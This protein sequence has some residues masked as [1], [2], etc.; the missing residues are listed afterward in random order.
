MISSSDI[1]KASILIVDD[2]EANVSLLEQ[3]LRGAGYV[4]VTSTR[5]PREVC[6]L[7]RQ[8]RYALILLD[9]QMP[10][11]DG[12]E[13]MA[14]LKEIETDGY[15]PVL[16]QTSQPDH[17]RRAL[18]SGAK[19]FVSKPFDLVEVLLRVH[20]LLEVRL[21][22]LET[23]RLYE[24]ERKVSEQLLLVFRS[25]PVAVSINTVAD[26][27]IIDANEEHCRFF[28]YSRAELVSGS[29]TD[30]NLWANPEDRTLVMQQLL[31][32]GALRGF[33]AK[34]R[35]KSGEERDVLAS[36]ELIE[37]AGENEPVLIFMLIDITER[38]Q[39]EEQL[40]ETHKQLLLLS[41]QA[42][43]AEI[44]TGVLHNVGNVLNSVN[45]ASSCLADSLG[46]S[47]VASLARVV[48]LLREHEGDLGTFLTSDPK[49]KLL[50][51]YLAQLAG[52]LV[53]EQAV[54]L[55]EL[56]DLQKN[57]EHI[58]QIVTL[59]QSFARVSGVTETFQVAEL[60]EDALWMNASA[61]ARHEVEII[62]E[63]AE[64]GPIT[65]ERHK[66]LQIL[67]NLVS[68]AKHAC[69]DSGRDHKQLTVRV[70]NGDGRIKIA[71]ADNGIGIPPEN[72]A[73]I[74]TH[75]FTTKKNGHGFG[76]HSSVLAAKEIG[77]SLRAHSEGAGQGATFILE[78]PIGLQ[79]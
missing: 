51:G 64:V 46:K 30:L 23:K 76:L 55:K 56:A 53:G 58:K 10:G 42:G 37:L 78:L 26:G 19:D 41:R 4:S 27:R 45:V 69:D 14:G 1:L 50:P 40:K 39:T 18:K 28:G 48:T 68:N 66:V 31:K 5:D 60:V 61:L 36:V 71:V 17:K 33:E 79:P 11:L 32:A 70:Y 63:F 15:L 44:A 8:N 54:A 62:R 16:V 73:R 35:L 34:Q 77:G 21:L 7:H 65:V 12:F 29:I 20:N 24:Q 6:E 59:Q 75:G 2:Q 72:L 13:V 25:G 57:I 47:K 22:H 3:M 9:L 43:M 67:V 49:G 38:K 52:H 74:F